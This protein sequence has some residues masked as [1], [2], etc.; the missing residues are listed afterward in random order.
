[1]KI[2]LRS[3]AVLILASIAQVS[4][5]AKYSFSILPTLGGET[6]VANSINIQGQIVG[7]SELVRID[8]NFG[9]LHAALWKNGTVTDLSPSEWLTVAYDINDDG[10]A[11]GMRHTDFDERGDAPLIWK[12][13]VQSNLP[14]L[15]GS[16]GNGAALA[17]NNTGLIVGRLTK[18]IQQSDGPCVCSVPVQWSDA[19]VK[20]IGGNIGDLPG[21]AIDI[22]SSGQIIGQSTF[23]NGV[24][25]SAFWE[26]ADATPKQ[27]NAA[28]AAL[29]DSGVVVGTLNY[30]PVYW[31]SDNL[32]E[33]PT[34][35]GNFGNAY[36]INNAGW[37][38]GQSKVK[39]SNWFH[40]TLWIDGIATDLNDFLS[41]SDAK[42][43][44]LTHASDINEQGAIVGMAVNRSTRQGAA[45]L[46]TSPVPETSTFSLM[47]L[48]LIAISH[49]AS[50]RRQSLVAVRCER[51]ESKI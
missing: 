44:E 6:A 13:S 31:E 9:N 29:N 25:G 37:I 42:I 46:L 33:L 43:W 26:S 5:A 48:G 35:G 21:M 14:G 10:T 41:E 22:N 17:I 2:V 30:R 27:I 24:T 7:R 3:I 36:A 1:M 45:F 51:I 15:Y 40:A 8:G 20:I 12:N 28:V 16:S 38:V 50:V 19:G 4:V 39:D 11:V 18:L 23:Q 47:F 49:L 34:L 32:V